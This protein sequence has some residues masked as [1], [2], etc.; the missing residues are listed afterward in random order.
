V[1]EE[2]FGEKDGKQLATLRK[3]AVKEG[4]RR[5]DEEWDGVAGRLLGLCD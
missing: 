2:M 4:S 5:W 3:G 1:L